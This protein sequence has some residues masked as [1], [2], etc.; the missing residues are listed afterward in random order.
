MGDNPV[1]NIDPDGMLSIGGIASI[2]AGAGA[3][4]RMASML[5]IATSRGCNFNNVY[6]LRTKDGYSQG[7]GSQLFSLGMAIFNNALTSVIL[8]N[9]MERVVSRF[10]SRGIDECNN[11]NTYNHRVFIKSR[12]TQMGFETNELEPNN[13]LGNMN[14]T[15]LYLKVADHYE[16][17]VFDPSYKYSNG[18]NGTY[19]SVKPIRSTGGFASDLPLEMSYNSVGK[20]NAASVELI[21]N[22]LNQLLGSV[23]VLP[24]QSVIEGSKLTI[25]VYDGRNQVPE[26]DV[27]G[28]SRSISAGNQAAELIRTQLK[29]MANLVIIHSSE[30]SYTTLNQGLTN[31]VSL[32][33]DNVAI[34]ISYQFYVHPY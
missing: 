4:V 12:L 32:A 14:P 17:V 7:L 9:G 11:P 28:R 24:R 15:F 5:E 30:A 19:L 25:T 8:N 21:S 22:N 13:A 27:E 18:C 29:G 10:V 1:V 33:Q 34:Q 2:A 23:P 26:D 31:V 16:R 20:L 6:S 3:A